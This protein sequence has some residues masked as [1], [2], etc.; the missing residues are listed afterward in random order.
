MKMGSL[1][2]GEG[3]SAGTLFERRL[4]GKEFSKDRDTS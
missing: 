4:S 2:D 1:F 3:S